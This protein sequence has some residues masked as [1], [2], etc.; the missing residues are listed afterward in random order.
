[1]RLGRLTC[2]SIPRRVGYDVTIWSWWVGRENHSGWNLPL[3]ETNIIPTQGLFEDDF[4]W[5]PRWDMLVPWRVIIIHQARN[6]LKNF[7]P[8]LHP[9]K[10]ISNLKMMA[11]K[12]E[13]SSSRASF[14]GSMWARKKNSLTFRSAACL[15]TGSYRDPYNGIIPHITG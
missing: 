2:D 11:S 6:S 15:M 5:F 7:P 14:S 12:K 3:L 9:Q 10:S 8:H 4:R 1:M 13:I